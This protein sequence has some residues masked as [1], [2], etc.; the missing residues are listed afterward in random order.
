MAA[1]SS[2]K[3]LRDVFLK[4]AVFNRIPTVRGFSSAP[5]NAPKIGYYSK[6]VCFFIPLSHIMHSI[7]Y[8]LFFKELFMCFSSLVFG[9]FNQKMIFK[10]NLEVGLEDA[11]SFRVTVLTTALYM[12][13]RVIL[14]LN[15]FEDILE[16]SCLYV[17]IFK[18]NM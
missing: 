8:V 11:N 1:C 3:L 5:Q 7:V 13:L 4:R 2:R 16:I 14:C 6:K 9:I 15:E 17:N 18:N 10:V 12:L